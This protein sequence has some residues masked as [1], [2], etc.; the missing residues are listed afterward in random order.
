MRLATL[1]LVFLVLDLHILYSRAEYVYENGQWIWKDDA[2][3]VDKT[4]AYED[5]EGSGEGDY[6]DD[7]E[8]YDYYE[9]SGA[10]AHGGEDT[11]SSY[12]DESYPSEK[13]KD[14]GYDN[15]WNTNANVN[16][17]KNNKNKENDDNNY[18]WKSADI[19]NNFNYN[20]NNDEDIQLTDDT[21][22][23]A[24]VTTTRTPPT[25]IVKLTTKPIIV[26]NTNIHPTSFFAQPGILAAVVGGAVVGLLCAI[27][28]VMFIVYRMRK[29]DEGSY[30]LDEPRRS[31]N[32]AH[33]YA[34]AN[35]REF[36]A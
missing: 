31:P 32:A 16:D 13:E 23:T 27:L 28:L 6:Y 24:V 4:P 3:P 5:S 18:N 17:I 29:K 26:G 21:K 19:N 34:K 1:I 10:E 25:T 11:S 7:S 8:D 35:S 2:Q 36:F 33:L 14:T 30:S 15:S 22:T 12:Y 9:G 20:Q